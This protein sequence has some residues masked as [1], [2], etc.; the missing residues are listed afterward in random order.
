MLTI[1]TPERSQLIN[2]VLISLL[3]TLNIHHRSFHYYFELI[4]VGWLDKI[5]TVST[6][7]NRLAVYCVVLFITTA[8]A[9]FFLTPTLI[10]VSIRAFMWLSQ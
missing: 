2:V 9:P 10:Q 6:S 4:N 1:K 3:L 8:T 5:Y 7:I